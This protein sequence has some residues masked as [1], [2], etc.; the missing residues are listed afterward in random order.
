VG[1]RLPSLNLHRERP[2]SGPKA[3]YDGPSAFARRGVALDDLKDG[4]G[5]FFAISTASPSK[6]LSKWSFVAQTNVAGVC[7]VVPGTSYL[8]Q[9]SLKSRR[10]W[11]W[12]PRNPC[13]RNFFGY[14]LLVSRKAEVWPELAMVSPESHRRRLSTLRSSDRCALRGVS[15]SKAATS[16]LMLCPLFAA[17][18]L[19]RS[20]LNVYY[21]GSRYPRCA[22]AAAQ[23]RPRRVLKAGTPLGHMPADRTHRTPRFTF[24]PIWPGIC[25]AQT[26]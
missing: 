5:R 12:C 13:P 3:R 24:N 2:S 19:L 21:P 9:G 16:A 8:S 6:C 1:D 7:V 22:H 11:L 20:A 25:R 15:E 4:N 18:R 17:E 26:G 10:N 14:I 23:A